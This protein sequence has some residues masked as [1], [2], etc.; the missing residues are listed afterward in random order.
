[1]SC[2]Q[3]DRYYDNVSVFDPELKFD[4]SLPA[5]FVEETHGV[6]RWTKPLKNDAPAS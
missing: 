3:F 4:D 1:M 2:K 6:Y 5:E